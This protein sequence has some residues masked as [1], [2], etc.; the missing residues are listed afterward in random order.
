ML[1]QLP[2][3]FGCIWP[4]AFMSQILS[5]KRK[6]PNLDLA[7]TFRALRERGGFYRP[8]FRGGRVGGGGEARAM[9]RADGENTGLT[10]GGDGGRRSR[11]GS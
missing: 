7:L 11:C 5:R 2:D 8:Q 4:T 3:D 10:A 1:Q 9:A 6:I